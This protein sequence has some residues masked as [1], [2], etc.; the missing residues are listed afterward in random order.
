M[1]L[2][3]TQAEGIN[4]ADTFAFTGTVSGAGK[5]L[6]TVQSLNSY[7]FSTNSTSFVDLESASGTV[8]VT[9]ITPSSSSNKILIIPSI[10]IR[11]VNS[12]NHSARFGLTIQSQIASGSPSTIFN[13]ISQGRLG[14]YDY[15]GSGL[16]VGCY[17]NQIFLYSPSTTS[18]VKI[19]FQV[20]A[21]TSSVSVQHNNDAY[22]S[23]CILQELLP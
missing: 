23:L 18:E 4:L 7:E 3:K 15:G 17:Y 1:P 2:V 6:Q 21:D 9:S 19:R 8:W 5:V 13:N 10:Y 20:R 14:G 12:S 22:D 11:T 16:Q